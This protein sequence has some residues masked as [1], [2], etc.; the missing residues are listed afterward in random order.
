MQ[1]QPRLPE[2]LIIGAMK[3]GTTSLYMD[4]ANL[5]AV[6]LAENKEPHHLC[7]DRVLSE[8]GRQEYADIY[9]GASPDTPLCD[10]STG[11]TK[12]PDQPGVA[13][14][15][16]AVLPDGFK[17]I[18]VVRHPVER[19][20]SH[21]RHDHVAR[22][23]GD[24][25]D[26]ELRVHRR[27]VDY[28]RYAMQ[29][30]PWLEAIGPERVLVVRFED[31]TE[32]RQEELARISA[33]LGRELDTESSRQKAYNQSQRKPRRNRFWDAVHGSS[34]YRQGLRRLAPLRLRLWAYQLLLPKADPPA[35]PPSEATLRWLRAE[36]SDDAA[37]LAAM[38]GRPTLWDDLAPPA[39]SAADSAAAGGA[40]ASRSDGASQ[41]V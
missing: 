3:S 22:T 23:V 11:Y 28:S 4:L 18:Y 25:I 19:A 34:L 7:D 24:D 13:S 37:E 16:L 5:G 12:L 35:A 39:D 27:Y 29:L 10:A 2:L 15:A 8:E 20:L 17:A 1:P 33:F 26:A 6:F 40:T 31:Y 14:R 41:S 9:R 32:R 36:L 21:Y 30:A 38:L